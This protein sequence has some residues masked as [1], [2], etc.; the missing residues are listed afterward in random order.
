MYEKRHCLRAAPFLDGVDYVG[1][2]Q[3]RLLVH[4][5]RESKIK[6]GREGIIER[7]LGYVRQGMSAPVHLLPALSALETY[8]HLERA[9]LLR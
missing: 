9:L 1:R 2:V 8:F 6:G 3:V 5:W 7:E 4:C